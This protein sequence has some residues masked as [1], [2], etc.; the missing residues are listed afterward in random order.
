VLQLRLELR[1]LAVLQ[2]GDLVEF[3]LAL[4]LHDPARTRSISP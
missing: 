4:E 2:L 1:E 3:A